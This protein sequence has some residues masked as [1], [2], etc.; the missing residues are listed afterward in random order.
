M[1]FN[2]NTLR[3]MLRLEVGGTVRVPNTRSF[4]SQNIFTDI[5]KPLAFT[6]DI[7][8]NGKNSTS[9]GYEEYVK[10]SS[11]NETIDFSKEIDVSENIVIK[12]NKF[13]YF[14]ETSKVRYRSSARSTPSVQNHLDIINE[15]GSFNHSYMLLD[16]CLFLAQNYQIINIALLIPILVVL[17]KRY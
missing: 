12:P 1:V 7:V 11:T 15:D 2:I 3:E 9:D 13:L 4:I 5:I 14:D 8:F 10:I 6:N 17:L 16:T